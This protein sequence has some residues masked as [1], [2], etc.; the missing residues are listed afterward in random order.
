[1]YSYIQTMGINNVGING[2]GPAWYF[3]NGREGNILAPAAY[4]PGTTWEKVRVTNFGV[5]FELL[6]HH[7]SGSAEVYQRDTK[8][9]LG[10]SFDIA[11]MFGAT[12][13]SSNNANLRTNGWELSLNY[14]GKINQD[15]GFSLGGVL[16][17]N[18]AVV[19]KYQNPT[20]F[21][22]SGNFYVGK[23]IG[24]IWGYHAD[25]LLQD[26]A[27]AAGFNKLDHSFIST[28]A[29]KPGDV[30]YLDLNGDNKI[31]NGANRLDSMGDVR[32][33]GNSTPRYAYAFTGSVD[34]KGLSLSFVIQGIAK[35]DFA[36][37]QGDAYFWG[38]GAYA[39]MT[40]F[41]QHMNYWTPTNPNAYY[42][43]PYTNTA[44]AIGAFVSKSEQ[45]SDR[46][47][48]NAAYMRLKNVTLSYSLPATLIKKVRLTKVSLFVSGENLYTVTKLSKMFDPETLNVSALGL[49][50]IYPLTKAFSTG[51]NIN[52]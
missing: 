10:P 46:Y 31:N 13:P 41:S 18:H 21:N 23:H 49:G 25:G 29:W 16:S 51:C 27:S 52:F 48:Q 3:Q 5:D 17:D 33:I 35:R 2:A 50:K 40:I 24:E 42:P 15:I 28:Q 39:Q 47:L 8:D 4:N 6:K 14:R 43:A 22:P 37:A 34:W 38:Y 9:M 1:M 26:S 32:I 7:L 12:V 45:T 19:T 30:K 20:F 36:P 44:G 11:D